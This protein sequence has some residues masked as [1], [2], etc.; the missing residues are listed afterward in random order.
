MTC[1]VCKACGEEVDH[2]GYPDDD[3]VCGAYAWKW[4]ARPVPPLTEAVVRQIVRDEMAKIESA[5]R[6][7]NS[8][9]YP[10][11]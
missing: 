3:C 1:W 11:Y 7:V 4:T 10:P 2:D 9:I 6:S 8:G 5:Y